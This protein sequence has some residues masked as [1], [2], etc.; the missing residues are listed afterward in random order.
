MAKCPGGRNQSEQSDLQ[1]GWHAWCAESKRVESEIKLWPLGQPHAHFLYTFL[2]CYASSKF[3]LSSTEY[4]CMGG[5]MLFAKGSPFKNLIKKC[6]FAN[7]SWRLLVVPDVL[8]S[9]EYLIFPI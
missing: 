9:S 2:F 7:F 8:P 5:K 3:S 6:Q 4:F 1:Q